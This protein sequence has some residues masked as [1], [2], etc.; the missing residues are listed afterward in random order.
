MI[1][2]MK[3]AM[4][5]RRSTRAFSDKKVEKKTVEEIMA[6]ASSA[7]SALN[8]QPWEVVVVA[9]EEKERLSKV[10]LKAY[11]ERKIPCG[12]GAVKRMPSEFYARQKEALGVMEPFINEAGYRFDPFINEGSCSFYD[13]PVAVLVFLDDSHSRRRLI[14]IG[15]FLAYLV[16]AAHSLGLGTCPIGIINPYGNEIR[17]FLNITDEKELMLGIAIGYPDEDSLVNRIRTDR[18]DLNKLVNWIF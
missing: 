7:P 4:E 13:A 15:V 1:L 17:E 12:P 9:G 8:L 5:T 11:G 3:E 16:L 14:C 18:V 10:I 2:N 6:L